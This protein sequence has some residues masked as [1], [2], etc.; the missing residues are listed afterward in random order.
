MTSLS[1]IEL[2]PMGNGEATR[3]NN[4]QLKENNTG[5][6][7]DGN[8]DDDNMTI[9]FLET[10]SGMQHQ[11]SNEN[12]N[13]GSNNLPNW[14][15]RLDHSSDAIFD[16]RRRAI[17]LQE[18]KRIQ[19]RSFWNFVLLCSLPL[20]L[21]TVMIIIVFSGSSDEVCMS[22][23]TYCRLEPRTFVNAFTTRCLCDPI[24]VERNS[25]LG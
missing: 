10:E 23:T 18:L 20:L 5:T 16:A 14:M 24:P 25:T 19:R 15:D 4:S 9:I 12:H 7:D 21:F 2:Q 17:L 1:N 6:S 11:G 13:N 3:Y 8:G 22:T